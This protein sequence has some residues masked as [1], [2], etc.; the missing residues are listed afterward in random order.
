MSEFRS[1]R[2]AFVNWTR[3]HAGGIETY[4]DFLLTAMA[5]RGH[6]VALWTEKDTPE[7]RLP[8]V[9]PSEASRWCAATDGVEVSV[10]ALQQ[11]APSVLLVHSMVD[12]A[13][14]ARLLRLAP[15]VFIAHTYTGTCISGGKTLVVPQAR[16]CQRRFGPACL[17]MFYPRRCGGLSP[18]TM[19][20]DYRR[21]MR[22][23]G[24]LRS[25]AGVLTLSEHMRQEYMRHGFAP[26]RV[27]ALPGY[28]PD[29]AAPPSANAPVVRDRPTLLFV[30]RIDRLK[31]CD[32][33]IE[34]LPLVQAALG[35][36]L[37]LVIAGDGPDATRC[38]QRATQVRSSQIEV[39]F[40]G[41]IDGDGRSRALAEADVVVVPSVWPEPYG[42][43]GLEAATAGV[44]VAAFRVGGIP[45]WLHDDVGRMASADP[46]TAA[47]LATAIAGCVSMGRRAPVASSVVS[48]LQERHVSALIATLDEL[49]LQ[50]S[51]AV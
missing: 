10:S 45:E 6:E 2:V 23:L 19:V 35:R 12:E 49:A 22:Q 33:L 27:R 4:V 5:E 17:A 13:L 30:G 25:Y 11:W 51:P 43:S 31:G 37:R 3:R 34:A 18:V 29:I 21:Q 20:T 32:L 9:V 40:R 14:E 47:G 26:D 50:Q 46:P 42:L 38:K 7:H 15:S 36:S 8:L 48:D 28:C 44:P 1:R 41:W 39:E 16:C 24:S